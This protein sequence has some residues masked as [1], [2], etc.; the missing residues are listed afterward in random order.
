MITHQACIDVRVTSACVLETEWKNPF[1]AQ[2]RLRDGQ[3]RDTGVLGCCC[4]GAPTV[5]SAALAFKLDPQQKR[6]VVFI[7]QTEA[8]S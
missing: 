6:N 4:R 2:V 7:N 1:G 3:V 8:R 5:I